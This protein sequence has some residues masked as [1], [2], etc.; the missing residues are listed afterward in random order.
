[1]L[2]RS[3]HIGDEYAAA[4]PDFVRFDLSYEAMEAVIAESFGPAR[5][6]VG[7]DYQ[8]HNATT[9]IEPGGLR[10]GVDFIS[11][12]EFAS[13]SL[14]GHWVA[15]IDLQAS[16]DLSFR[17]AKSAVAGMELSRTGRRFPALRIVAELFS[18]PTAAGQFYGN[19]ERYIGLAGYITR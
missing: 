17:V 19:S 13:R 16:R 14:R 1:M 7:G 6:Y 15:G 11:R 10:A 12:A 3:S 18:G 4:H 9:A 8:V 2:H 5:I